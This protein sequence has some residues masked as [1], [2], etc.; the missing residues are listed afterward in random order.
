MKPHKQTKE[1]MDRFMSEVAP[2]F[3]GKHQERRAA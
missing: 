1:E 3:Q 2:H